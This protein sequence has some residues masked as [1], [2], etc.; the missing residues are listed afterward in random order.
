MFASIIH[1]AYLIGHRLFGNAKAVKKCL[2]EKE[3]ALS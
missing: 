1:E 2:E 3:F